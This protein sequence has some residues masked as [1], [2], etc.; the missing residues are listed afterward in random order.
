MTRK[1]RN[2]YV[3]YKCCLENSEAFNENKIALI[4]IALK[5]KALKRLNRILSSRFNCFNSYNFNINATR[6][7]TA[8]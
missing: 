5:Q 2:K 1:N 6:I 4:I 8:L 3:L 7:Q